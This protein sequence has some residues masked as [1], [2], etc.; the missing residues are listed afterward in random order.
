MAR[1][2]RALGVVP[3]VVALVAVAGAAQ[4]TAQ[5]SD[6]A[7]DNPC[8]YQKIDVDEF[9]KQPFENPPEIR[10][11]NGVLQ[12]DLNAQYTDPTATK[13]AGCGIHLR[14]YN[15]ELVGPTLRAKP[16]D[17]LRI[18]LRNLLPAE[19]DAVTDAQ[20]GQET[21]HAHL[22]VTPVSYN[23]TNLHTHGLHV[24]PVDRG[25]N[26]L[27]H[28][29]PQTQFQY[30]IEI[31]LDQPVGT[32]WYHSHAHGSTA[33]QVGSGM[34]GALIIEDDPA[35]IPAALDATRATEKVLFFAAV[36]YD[37]KG[38]VENIDMFFPDTG[39]KPCAPD[40]PTCTLFRSQRL[41]TVNGQIV[42]TIRMRPG[43]VQRWRLIDGTFNESIRLHLEDHALHEIALDGIYTGTVDRWK[44][45]QT[46]DLAPGYRSDVLV[47]AS[48]KPGTYELVD[49]QTTPALSVRGI[50][51]RRQV[52]ANVVVE[53]DPVKMDLLSKADAETLNP[54]PGVDLAAQE[55]VFDGVDLASEKAAKVP[56]GIQRAIFNLNDNASNTG[57][58]YFQ[59][60]GLSFDPL[61]G[62]N[63]ALNTTDMWTLGSL[64]GP[65]GTK[66]P[67]PGL[68]HVFHIHVNSFQTVREGPDGKPQTVW[69][70]TLLVRPGRTTNV[71]TRYTDFT[72]SFVLHCHLLDHEDLGM[73]MKVTVVDGLP[74]PATDDPSLPED[75]VPIPID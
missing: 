51:E 26:V 39:P 32:Y 23:T 13:V 18:N 61:R 30:E 3:S 10:S 8:A 15:G 33:V 22:E 50:D 62:I 17:V 73:M 43:E 29:P 28:I 75:A 42:P 25:D 68:P 16:G 41:T 27:L 72:G 34:A 45:D 20:V 19:S 71:F 66:Q 58:V 31:P 57:H 46:I 11:V 21:E 67:L 1:W 56:I 55:G 49:E 48:A 6:P 70:D 4:L 36:P 54:F 69:K 38:E 40:A 5:G 53:G 74:L 47:Q 35:T 65:R 9:G 59:V 24:S 44:P 52:L 14:S 64:G 2:K 60:N 12:T 37:T 7:S 63:A